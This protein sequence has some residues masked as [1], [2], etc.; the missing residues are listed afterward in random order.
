[1][2][3]MRENSLVLRHCFMNLLKICLFCLYDVGST[4]SITVQVSPKVLNVTTGQSA[5]LDC[6]FFTNQPLN[7]LMVQWTLYPWGSENPV[8]VSYY[9][10]VTSAS[11]ISHSGD[12]MAEVL[13]LH[14][15]LY[16]I[17]AFFEA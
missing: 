2:A 15:R 9:A 17:F 6:N 8:Q 5:R 1:M 13:I 7:S 4:L 12:L 10:K 14:L 3:L 11:V 16:I